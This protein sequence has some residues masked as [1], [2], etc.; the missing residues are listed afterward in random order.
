MNCLSCNIVLD[1]NNWWACRRKKNRPI[2]KFCI[3]KDN[4]KRYLKNRDM[5]LLESKKERSL[6]KAEV[7][8]HYGSKCQICDESD[9]R[10]L[11]LDHINGNGRQHRKE[12]LKID[13]GS[14][15]YK[16]VNDNKPDNLRLLCFN[17]N[18]KRAIK[19]TELIITNLDYLENKNCKYCSSSV[20]V[21][22]YICSKC[23][24]VAKYN[25]QIRL[26]IKVY[27]TYGGC[28]KECKCSRYECLTIDHINNNGAE[29]R[30]E[31]GLNIYC[32]LE[33]NEFPKDNFQLLCYNCNYLKYF[34]IMNP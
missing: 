29:H 14:G 18:C 21:R 10:K 7:I 4:K 16:W 33:D 27:D 19:Q 24:Y 1:D 31:V 26:K 20:K 9:I 3:L 12:V 34:K 13:S 25:K 17:C 28:C 30:K 6:I 8:S 5:I 15:F 2:C 32:W 22:K 23:E 11:S